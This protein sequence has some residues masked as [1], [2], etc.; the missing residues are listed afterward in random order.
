M[1]IQGSEIENPDFYKKRKL[2][3]D[4]YV[5]KQKGAKEVAKLRVSLLNCLRFLLKIY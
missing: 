1:L 4:L 2:P 3:F 5:K